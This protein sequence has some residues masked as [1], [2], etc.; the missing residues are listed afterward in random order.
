MPDGFDAGSSWI[1]LGVSLDDLAKG[2][3]QGQRAT[4][5]FAHN[6]EQRV[7][8]TGGSFGKL[9][10]IASGIFGGVGFKVAEVGFDLVGRGAS[11][12]FGEISGGIDDARNSGLLLAQTENVIRS[13][14]AAAGV[15]ADH[16]VDLASALSDASGASLFGDDQIQESE[17]LLLTFTNI[18]GATL[19]AATAISVDLAQ[20]MGGAPKDS[21]IQLG[22]ALNDPIKGVSA[23]SRVGVTFTEQQK[24]QI[25]V[26][27]ESGDMAGAQAI[28]LAELNKEFGG[29]AAA[30]AAAADPMVRFHAVLGETAEGIG[31]S[32]LPAIDSLTGV[33]TN[34]AVMAGITSIGEGLA[35][36]IGSAATWLTNT[37]IPGLITGWQTLSPILTTVG[38]VLGTLGQ[39]L[40]SVVTSGDYLNDWLT[41][42][43]VPLQIVAALF[44]TFIT[45]VQ[46]WGAAIGTAVGQLVS[47]NLSGAFTTLGTAFQDV[48]SNIEHLGMFIGPKLLEIGQSIASTV[49]TWGQAFIGWVA[50]MIPVVLGELGSLASS[51]IGWIGEQAGPILAQLEAWGESFISWIGPQIPVLL[52]KAAELGQAFI[53]WIGQQAAPILAKLLT[54][55]ESLI[56]W[57]VPATRDFL[58]KWPVMFDQFL[59]WIGA[60]AGPLLAKL[61]EWA[62]SFIAWVIPMI[63]PFL[64][65]VAG[66]AAALLIWVGETAGVLARKII[67]EWVPA[68]VNWIATD[69][70]PKIGPAL[71]GLLSTI[72]GW[73]SSAASSLLSM[74]A[75]MGSSIVSGIQN[76]ISNAWGTFLGWV[77]AQINK[78]PAVIRKALGIGSPSRVMAEIGRWIP[79]GLA[80]GIERN[81][82]TVT[83][84]MGGLI[85]SPTDLISATDATLNLLKQESF[86]PWAEGMN[87]YLRAASGFWMDAVAD[88]ISSNTSAINAARGMGAQIGAALSVG[89]TSPAGSGGSVIPNS[90]F[91]TLSRP[92]AGGTQQPIVIHQT[93][94]PG[95]AQDVRQAAR[96]G[97]IEGVEAAAR[98]RGLL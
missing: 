74:A 15:S 14:G 28:I 33:L 62:T 53:G 82:G 41:G 78:I 95:T 86:V 90:E 70:I 29:S 36:G 88:G 80:D 77:D 93:F 52:G 71:G 8:S 49:L 97:G 57:I 7:E 21:A 31:A 26:M 23:L 2:F 45:N 56:A 18:K 79:A 83:D 60:Q 10:S 48:M 55:G 58:A 64:A 92:Q 50:P 54:W 47:G 84:A 85:G 22:K 16:I 59:S 98:S 38:G 25:R 1:Q 39:Y 20:A 42:L 30:T 65:A 6:V 72:G 68:L 19:D 24:E 34:P 17:N 13:T 87:D 75:A 37:A 63:P 66:I 73:I 94:G 61:G 43:P 12:A 76:G 4:D 51:L 46:T 35:S 44:G 81:G 67:T 91:H 3:A 5:D 9:G 11:A 69:A 96:Q 27:Q 89:I 32:L 40:M